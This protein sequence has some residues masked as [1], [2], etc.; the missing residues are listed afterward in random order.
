MQEQ[1]FV[2]SGRWSNPWQWPVLNSCKMQEMHLFSQEG[3]LIFLS[4]W[5]SEAMEH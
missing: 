1:A 2:Y 4:Q 5:L 3:L